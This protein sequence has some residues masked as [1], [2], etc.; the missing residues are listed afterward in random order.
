MHCILKIAITPIE[1]SNIVQSYYSSIG[2]CSEDFVFNLKDFF[3]V[4]Y[5]IFIMLILIWSNLNKIY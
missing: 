5:I 2:L 3:K 1:A 4:F